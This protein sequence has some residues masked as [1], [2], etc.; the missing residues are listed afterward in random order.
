MA[1]YFYMISIDTTVY[2]GV[3]GMINMLDKGHIIKLVDSGLS[4]REVG[5]R[6]GVHRKTVAKYHKEHKE[7][8]VRLDAANCPNIIRDIQ[9]EIVSKPVYPKRQTA[10][11]KWTQE[12]EDFIDNQLELEKDR[13]NKFGP[14]HK[15]RITNVMV[16]ELMLNEGFSIGLSSVQARMKE[17]RAKINEVFIRQTYKPGQRFEFDYGEFDLMINGLKKRCH[18]AVISSPYSDYRTA[19]MYPNQKQRTFM[20]AHVRLMRQIGG[21]PHEI[22]YDNMRN[23]VSKFIGK[24]EKQLNENL[25]KLSIYY[26]FDINVTNCFSGNEKGHV[27]GSVRFIRNKVF[28]THYE[29][30]SF[31][32]AENHLATRVI[33]LN[34][35]S[36]IEEEKPHLRPFVAD[37]DIA[38]VSLLKVNKY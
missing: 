20:D 23:V 10:L 19:Y 37:L 32:A 33:E 22:V 24:S 3:R 21:V 28:T 14:N 17:K 31:E 5:K 16:H 29:F 35:N 2:G 12:M 15:Q 26:G 9:N 27:E 4:Y 36:K 38:E 18:M 8:M 25:V 11:R 13:N 30:D 34:K 7:L 1:H 6:T